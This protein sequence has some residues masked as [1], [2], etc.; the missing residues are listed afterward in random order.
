MIVGTLEVYLY[1]TPRS[2]TLCK[3]YNSAVTKSL[4]LT[5]NEIYHLEFIIKEVKR[6]LELK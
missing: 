3:H 5:E 4:D 2:I 1:E 6:K